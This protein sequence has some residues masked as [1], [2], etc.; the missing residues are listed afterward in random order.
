MKK[1]KKYK[2]RDDVVAKLGKHPRI[3]TP[4]QFIIW[5]LFNAKSFKKGDWSR[6]IKHATKLFKAYPRLDFWK[7]IS[8]GDLDFTFKSLIFL[9]SKKWKGQEILDKKFTNYMV[10]LKLAELDDKKK[11]VELK[12]KS[13][14]RFRGESKESLKDFLS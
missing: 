2:L 14:V 13:M 12:K 10:S 3:Y 5:T 7:Q 1:D 6:E 4:E 11:D 9:T 8:F